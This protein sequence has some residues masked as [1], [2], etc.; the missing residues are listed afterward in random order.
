M[1]E[2]DKIPQESWSSIFL[3]ASHRCRDREIV[4]ALSIPVQRSN[5]RHLN[6]VRHWPVLGDTGRCQGKSTAGVLQREC[7]HI[8]F[9]LT[10]IVWNTCK[11]R[12]KETRD[13]EVRTEH[14]NRLA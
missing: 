12:E 5:Q 6:R 2:V 4:L 11:V 8:I 7:Y 9:A 1:Q 10:I 14:T 13:E 3:E